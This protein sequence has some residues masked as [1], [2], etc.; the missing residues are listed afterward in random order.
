MN[1]SE[2]LIELR[3][4]NGMSQEA[5]AEKLGVSRQTVS[6]WEIGTSTPDTVN[7]VALSKLFDVS[8]DQLLLDQNLSSPTV[9]TGKPSFIEKTQQTL[10]KN[11]HLFGYALMWRELRSILGC[12]LITWIYLEALTIIGIPLRELPIQAFI[13]PIAASGVSLICLFRLVVILV[14][15][16]KFK[17]PDHK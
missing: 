8:T 11:G 9:S 10:Q 17:D 16:L 13:L 2:K 14:F 4:K 12:A 7:I 1:F 5:L 3:K 15:T 6:K